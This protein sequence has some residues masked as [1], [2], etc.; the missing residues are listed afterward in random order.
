MDQMRKVLKHKDDYM[1][2]SRKHRARSEK[3][4]LENPENLGKWKEMYHFKYGAPERKL[5]NELN[6]IACI[7]SEN[8]VTS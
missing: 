6:G 3:R 2:S 8:V 4:F 1:K 5:L 7:P